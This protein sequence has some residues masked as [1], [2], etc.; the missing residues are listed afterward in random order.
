[1]TKDSPS[2]VDVF[3]SVIASFFGVQSDKN[4]RRDFQKGDPMQFIVVGLILTL[5]FIII[6][7]A[8]VKVVLYFT[9]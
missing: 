7:I 3:K 9:T 5:I 2:I 4:R 6:V 1:M 8:L